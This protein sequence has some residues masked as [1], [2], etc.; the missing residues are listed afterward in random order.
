MEEFAT[1]L[2]SKDESL[3]RQGIQKVIKSRPS[4]TTE[5]LIKAL[6]D[7]SV[8]VRRDALT[9]LG[10]VGDKKAVDPVIQLL[11]GDSD[12]TTEAASVLGKLADEAAIEQLIK[13]LQNP[14]QSRRWGIA[15]AL[16]FIR[17]AKAVEPLI[18]VLESSNSDEDLQACCISALGEI[19]DLRAVKPIIKFLHDKSPQIRYEVATALG[20][21]TDE[22]AFQNLLEM[23][24][25]KNQDVVCNAI[26]ALG[27]QGDERAVTPLINILREGDVDMR[28]AVVLALGILGSQ[29]ALPALQWTRDN[30]NSKDSHHM[31]VKNDAIEAIKTIEQ[32]KHL[33]SKV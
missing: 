17:D 19:K 7:S 6:K 31:W 3:R 9:G 18:A 30:D 4:L 23:L 11:V 26:L 10:I 8:M 27:E 20:Y 16:G 29:E 2:E 13:L 25:D 1:L 22:E 24:T 21:L 33:D 14:S 32:K 15:F 12:L 28:R 5:I